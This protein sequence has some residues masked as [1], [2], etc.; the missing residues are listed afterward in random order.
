MRVIPVLDLRGG[1]AVHARGGDRARY[2][3][4][5]S[6]V[7]PAAPPGDALA[8]ARGDRDALALADR[9]VA[10]LAALG[11]GAPDA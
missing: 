7:A 5:R 2:E 6:A 3:P 11:G 1:R 4:V 9:Y 10:D 8:L